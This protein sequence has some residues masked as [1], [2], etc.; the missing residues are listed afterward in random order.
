MTV[1]GDYLMLSSFYSPR[2]GGTLGTA[3]SGSVG[4]GSDTGSSAGG[5]GTL[6]R[7]ASGGR[8]TDGMFLLCL[9]DGGSELR[10]FVVLPPAAAALVMM[11]DSVDPGDGVLLR[12]MVGSEVNL[13]SGMVTVV[14]SSLLGWKRSA[15][16]SSIMHTSSSRVRSEGSG[17]SMEGRPAVSSEGREAR[18][19]WKEDEEEDEEDEVVVDADDVFVDDDASEDAERRAVRK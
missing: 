17:S 13:P 18:N 15:Q 8:G 10:T 1:L 2:R 7:S 9:N 4:G 6:R 3:G 19:G 12:R 14:C 5:A 16:P 11:D